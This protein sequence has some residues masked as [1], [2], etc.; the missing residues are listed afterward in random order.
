[1]SKATKIPTPRRSAVLPGERYGRLVVIEFAGFNRFGHR[2]WR[3]ICDCGNQKIA[4]G[5]QV[6]SGH[7]R[8]CGCLH[9]ETL[10]ARLTTHGMKNIPEYKIWKAIRYRCNQPRCK[11]FAAYGGRGITVCERWQSFENFYADMG[12]RP[13]S[14]H[15]IDRIDNDAGY[16]P[17]N[18][19]WATA[20]EQ[21][22]N[23]RRQKVLRDV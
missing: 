1:M 16:K 7:T 4:S 2:L 10:R 17:D 20:T 15:S 21:R 8:S 22:L 3:F 5:S 9:S 13:S 12:S 11:D 23:Q 18:C 6:R 14:C 19:R